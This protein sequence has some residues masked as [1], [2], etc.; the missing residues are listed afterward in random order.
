ML[1]CGIMAGGIGT[2]MGRADMPKQFICINDVPVLIH[3][4]R[5]FLSYGGFDGIVI[6]SPRQHIEATRELL[7]RYCPEALAAVTEGGANRNGSLLNACMYLNNN[8]DVKKGDIIVTHDA[9]RPFI[10][11]R[12]I[13]QNIT[14]ARNTGAANTVMPAIDTIVRSIDGITAHSVPLRSELYRVQTPQTFELTA[15][16][17]ILQNATPEQLEKYTD[18]AGLYMAAGHTVT[19]VK[20]EEYN[21][22]ITT[23]FDLTVAQAF[24]DNEQQA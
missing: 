24:L 13:E 21:I 3:T 18:A 5:R 19:L 7:H 14:A 4:V 20:G 1:Y 16:T 10:N 6:T 11:N 8:F 22:K 17:Q 12:I 2:R 9:V 23:P 15:L